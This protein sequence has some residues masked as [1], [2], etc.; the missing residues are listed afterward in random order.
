MSVP[1]AWLLKDRKVAATGSLI[2]VAALP[3]G[4]KPGTLLA[5]ASLNSVVS[6][7]C[8]KVLAASWFLLAG[9][10][11]MAASTW[12]ETYSSLPAGGGTAK[13]LHLNDGASFSMAEI[14]QEPSN[15][16]AALPCVNSC[17]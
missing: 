2:V 6:S 10:M 11:P 7:H 5:K 14:C 4:K 1:L 9:F 13:T 17:V 15:R 3:I 12:K 16:T 8:R